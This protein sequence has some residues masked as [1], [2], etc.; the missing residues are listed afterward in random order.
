MISSRPT[1]PPTTPPTI[2]PVLLFELEV[3]LPLDP[4][5]TLEEEVDEKDP[6]EEDPL[7]DD[8]VEDGVDI[9]AGAVV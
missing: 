3:A 2:G 1:T 7:E 6:L 4:A 5:G 9:T 8:F